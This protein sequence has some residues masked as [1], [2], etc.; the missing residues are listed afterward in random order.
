MTK[1]NQKLI[2]VWSTV[3]LAVAIVGSACLSYFTNFRDPITV[4]FK[5]LYPGVIIGSDLI[6]VNDLEQAEVI[7]KRFGLNQQ[8]ARNRQINN[9]RSYELARRMKIKVSNDAAADEERFYSVGNESEYKN[10]LQSKFDNSKRAFYKYVLAPQVVDAHLR[11]KYYSGIKNSSPAYAR[12]QAALERLDKGEKFEV[13]AKEVSDDKATAQLGGDL[14]FY[15]S[16]QLIPELEDQVSVSALGEY[17]KDI[18][19]TRL[20]YHLVYPV[21]YSNDDGKKLWHVKHMLFVPE[22][23]DNWLAQQTKNIRIR[24]I[25]K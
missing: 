9:E 18:I 8:D 22:G 12:A 5:R 15:E 2:I 20:G 11:I 1:Q 6:S 17:R 3:G 16:G 24:Y 7:G 23:Y 4:S 25:M 14:G 21:E 19:V 10:V 13:V